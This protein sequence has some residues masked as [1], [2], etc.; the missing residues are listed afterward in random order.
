MRLL[1]IVL[2]ALSIDVIVLVHDVADGKE[3]R[4]LL[5]ARLFLF[6]FRVRRRRHQADLIFS[7]VF[8]ATEG[9]DLHGGGSLSSLG[10]PLFVVVLV[11]ACLLLPRFGLL[12]LLFVH[13]VTII[14]GLR[15][16]LLT[17]DDGALRAAAA[18]VW[19]IVD[20][21]QS[22]ALFEDLLGDGLLRLRIL[23]V[24]RARG[25][26]QNHEQVDH[27]LRVD[28]VDDFVLAPAHQV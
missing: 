7:I 12:C 10:E 19:F 25:W 9:S 11:L 4:G 13:L 27:I 14:T 2:V 28:L 24:L 18:A 20:S 5:P 1:A 26:L 17:V 21:E 6:F 8:V 15:I 22:V 16:G 23:L 3:R